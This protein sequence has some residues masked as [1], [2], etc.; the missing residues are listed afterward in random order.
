MYTSTLSYCFDVTCYSLVPVR[1][2][3]ALIS[4]P[5]ELCRTM[6]DVSAE[7]INLQATTKRKRNLTE[8]V[9]HVTLKVFSFIS[10]LRTG[11][12]LYAMTLES[13]E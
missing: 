2:P 12:S 3:C 4:G 8:E 6:Q 1:S 9:Y 5:H 13:G 11:V 7:G 10:C